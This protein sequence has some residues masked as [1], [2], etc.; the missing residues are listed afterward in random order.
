MR[1]ASCFRCLEQAQLSL[2]I[3]ALNR[4]ALLPGKRGR[5]RGDDRPCSST[6]RV[7][8]LPVL[9]V[10]EHKIHAQCVELSDL[11]SIRCRPYQAAHRLSRRNQQ[12]TDLTTEHPRCPDDQVHSSPPKI[13]STRPVLAADLW[14]AL[15]R[16]RLRNR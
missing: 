9:Q 2:Q 15:D 13:E 1:D 11:V 4:I 14:Y 6:G 3:D 8:R 16:L 12:P 10:P 5:G 7:E